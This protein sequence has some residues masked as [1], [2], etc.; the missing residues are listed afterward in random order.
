MALWCP[1]FRKNL[2]HKYKTLTRADGMV[3]LGGYF[4]MYQQKTYHFE[5]TMLCE[6]F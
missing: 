1:V 6:Y 2:I 4:S 5:I 3:I